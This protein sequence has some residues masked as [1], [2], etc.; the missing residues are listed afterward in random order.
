MFVDITPNDERWYDLEDLPNE[1]WRDVKDFEGLYQVSNYGRVKSLSRVL[2]YHRIVTKTRIL[3]PGKNS[4]YYY[5]VILCKNSKKYTKRVHRLVADVF[6]PNPEQKPEVNHIKY[7]TKDSCDNTVANLEWVT[8][9]ENSQHCKLLNRNSK[10]P[11]HYGGDNNASKKVYQY[12]TSGNLLKT[13]QCVREVCEYVNMNYHKFRKY[14]MS[15][16]LI[17]DYIFKYAETGGDDYAGDNNKS[18]KN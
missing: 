12:D 17:N 13:W 2:D 9:K 5:V 6:I 14:V 4:A 7:V 8:S 15:N 10:P 11:V 16:N 3:R 1:E 18:N